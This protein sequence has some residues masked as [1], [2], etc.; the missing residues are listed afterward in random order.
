MSLS[1]HLKKKLGTFGRD[2]QFWVA[3]SGGMDSHVLLDCCANLKSFKFK[4]IHINHNLHP[5]SKDWTDH[6]RKVASAYNLEFISHEIDLSMKQG[7]SLE[8]TARKMR[9]QSIAT[10]MQANDVLLTAHHEDDQA[11]T[12][13]LQLFRGSGV[14]G[15][16][17]MPVLRKF[18]RGHHAR[19]FLNYSRSELTCYAQQK[20]LQWIEDDSNQNTR[21]RRN[22]VR[23]SL[24]PLIREHLPNVTHCMSRS[25]QHC[26][27]ASHILMQWSQHELTSFQG[28]KPHTLSIPCLL[29]ADETK[30]N[31]L[32]RA[33]LKQKH[34][35]LPSTKKLK[36]IRETILYAQSDKQPCVRF[37]DIEIRR[38]QNDLYAMKALPI[39]DLKPRV[40]D[41]NGELSLKDIGTLR[42]VATNG[43]GLKK[44][45]EVTIRFRSGGEKIFLHGQHKTLKNSFQH[46]GIPVW[47]RDRI[48]LIYVDEK[49]VCVVDYYVDPR[50]AVANNECGLTFGFNPSY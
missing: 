25:A 37:G 45:D 4:V 13:L 14:D 2:R 49:L 10:Y 6:C 32:I 17:A 33:W 31:L 43:H 20:G 38:H 16:A 29:T 11:E 28:S 15:L 18:I 50:F 48:P 1:E 34:F 19:P 47:L 22:W 35:N 40:W 30:Q 9:Y 26:A 3:Y 12:L 7:D 24:I 41:L 42:V 5:R 27:Q 44:I 8:E 23:H 21:F 36:T 39:H 46:W